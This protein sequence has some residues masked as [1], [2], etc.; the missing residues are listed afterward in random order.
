[1]SDYLIEK[2]IVNECISVS[3]KYKQNDEANVFRKA[4]EMLNEELVGTAFFAGSDM[5]TLIDF[6]KRIIDNPNLNKLSV[7]FVNREYEVLFKYGEINQVCIGAKGIPYVEC[8]LEQISDRIKGFNGKEI[9]CIHISLNVEKLKNFNINIASINL[10]ESSLREKILSSD[11][12]VLFTNATSV[13]NMSEQN[14]LQLCTEKPVGIV[15]SSVF[16][17]G[18]DLLSSTEEVGDVDQR[19]GEILSKFNMDE[20]YLYKDIETLDN[21]IFTKLSENITDLR[22]IRNIQIASDSLDRLEMMLDQ[23]NKKASINAKE[24]DELK[25]TMELK[26]KDILHQGMASAELARSNIRV[27]LSED[28]YGQIEECNREIVSAIK[29]GINKSNDPKVF[30]D[31]IPDYIEESWKQYEKT[32]RPEIES[33]ASKI[34]DE[35]YGNMESDA[36]TFFVD[37]SEDKRKLLEDI[38]DELD[39]GV[40][41]NINIEVDEKDGKKLKTASKLLLLSAIPVTFIWGFLPAVAAAAGGVALKKYQSH[42]SESTSKEELIAKVDGICEQVKSDIYKSYCDDVEK[43]ADN[44]QEQIKKAYS[45]FAD[46][47]IQAIDGVRNEL[48]TLNNQ[49]D[50]IRS[51]KETRIPELKNKLALEF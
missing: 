2:E 11:I 41:R 22:K 33:K 34:L 39:I 40:E 27:T 13:F 51:L 26:R 14:F 21:Y 42:K 12:S 50:E 28:I 4:K 19:T 17:Y 18:I 29:A 9:P 8:E 1:M 10:D 6:S 46:K 23:L 5:R 44:A 43:M 30:I 20:E 35:V 7:G 38:I 24:V 37:V 32:I 45:K 16:V 49:V 47:I 36:S 3:E 25:S 31:R 15:R 48:S